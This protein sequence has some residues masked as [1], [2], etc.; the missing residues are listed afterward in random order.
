M[1]TSLP[2]IYAAGDC[3]ESL[4]ISD[5]TVKV[6]AL[7]PNAYIQGQCAGI[8]MAGGQSVFDKAI[9]MN[10][11]GFFGLHVMTAGS[12][13]GPEEGGKVYEEVTD[14]RVKKLYIKDG[15]L[16]G[17]VL[18]GDVDRAGIYTDLIRSGTPLDSLDFE[19]LKK[20]PNLF[21]FD[22]KSREK[23]LGGVV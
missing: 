14:A 17:F 23:K 7:L 11:I 16:A 15:K 12:S 6:M 18:V 1:R 20:I 22:A 3:T 2:D 10:S 13:T 19:K 4:D 5:R 21:A 8:N 9:P